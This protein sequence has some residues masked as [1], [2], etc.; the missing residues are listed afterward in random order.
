MKANPIKIKKYFFKKV[1][2]F[3]GHVKNGDDY[4]CPDS[5]TNCISHIYRYILTS[6]YVYKNDSYIFV[7]IFLPHV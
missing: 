2:V 3:I 7:I 5:L 6:R 1:I 4:L